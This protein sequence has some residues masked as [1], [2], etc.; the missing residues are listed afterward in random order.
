MKHTQ[1]K[2]ALRNIGK[3]KISFL[4]ILVIAA[5]G[6]V[7]FLG[8]DYSAA[9]LD[10][11][12]TAFYND[13]NFRDIEIVSTRL[14]SPEDMEVLRGIEGV[15][16]V[17]G[18]VMTQAKVASGTIRKSV[19]VTTFSDRINRPVLLQGQLPQGPEACAVEKD[20]AR[21]MGWQVGDTIEIT[22]TDGQQAQFLTRKEYVIEGLVLHPDH[23]ASAVPDTLYI[24]VAPEAF[25]LDLFTGCFMKAELIVDAPREL[26]RFE[27]PYT[28]AVEQVQ[29]RIDAISEERIAIRQAE[30]DSQITSVAEQ[31]LIADWELLENAKEQIRST[32]RNKL[33]EL[34][35]EKFANAIIWV[36]KWE[37]NPW[38]EYS[39]ALS[40]Y[41]TENVAVDLSLSLRD[42]VKNLLSS[43]DLPDEVLRGAFVLLKGQGDY[44]PE[45]A[46]ALAVDQIMP[47][48]EPYEDQYEEL[49]RGCYAWNRV[50]EKFLDGTLWEEIG[51]PGVC[52]WIVTNVRGNMSFVQL[53]S[54]R[55]SMV[56]LEM[57][58]SLLFMVV[59]ALVIY[60]TV[61]KMIDEQRNLVGATKALGFYTREIFAKYLLFGLSGT[62][63]GTVLGFLIARFGVQL[64]IL[65][66]YQIFY[67][68][69][70]TRST[71]TCLPTLAVFV[72]GALLSVCAVWFA[73]RRLLK[74]PAVALLQ[75]A[76]PKGHSKTGSGKKSVLPLYSR[77]ILRNIRSD[78]RRV[79]VTVVSVAGC[80][81]LVVV[82][83]TLRNSVQGSLTKQFS[84]IVTYDG[85]YRFDPSV[86]E[87][88]AETMGD[89]LRKAGT[90]V[91]PVATT[92]CT[93]KVR[94]LDLEELYCGDLNEIGRL[95]RL[96][97][98]ETG[99]PIV[100][101]DQG[102]YVHKRFSEY[103]N[104]PVGYPLE[105]TI[106]A[107]ETVKVPVVG[108]F[109]NY[110]NRFLFMSDTCFQNLFGR[111]PRQN[112]F[113]VRLNGADTEELN[114]GFS[115]MAGF[116]GYT[117]SDSFRELFRT[118]TSVMN[119]VVV[120]FIFMAAI[121]AGVVVMNLTNIYIL[122]KKR[123]LTVMRINGFTTRETIDYVLRETVVT[124]VLGILL[125]IG[126]GA[127]LG[128]AIVCA[129]EPPFIQFDRSI[130]VVAWVLAAAMTVF[131]TVIINAI[132]L[133]K[134]KHLKLTDAAA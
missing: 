72:V 29:S 75:A 120:L 45:A 5:L 2:D 129:L 90:Q 32:I 31:R 51:L 74:T 44:S 25:D 124:T 53:D 78:L 130:S 118:A 114:E 15:K 69:D 71:M 63:L 28:D 128:Y 106:N 55:D 6:V 20:L 91:C 126:L 113:L 27:G 107:T 47:V 43:L 92:Y 56:R 121:M 52:R 84:R 81:A 131:F 98:A 64:F 68:V 60:A 12:G 110:M 34:L 46:T 61:S 36:T 41:I 26:S 83:L 116:E 33:T 73:C 94:N 35:G 22:G 37:V 67:R 104:V 13:A 82:G 88:A 100:P 23:V 8:I 24:L 105:I 57:T 133:R 123:E 122:Q 108:V 3:Q 99:A 115:K 85:V 101:S 21:D 30:V 109:D 9:A 79:I 7:M 42:N 40:F 17:E 19:N 11:N 103:F 86:N 119:A 102:V 134:V 65:N 59:G 111:S 54:S 58:F 125:G 87:A 77:L 89:A 49:T 62:V 76:M 48:L 112:A 4:S 97:D 117:P 66:G 93:V 96:Y 1:F 14:L 18:T 80:C 10:A 132:V 16:D 95:F 39:D 127:G 38:D 70:I 50:H